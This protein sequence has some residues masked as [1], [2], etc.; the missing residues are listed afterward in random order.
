MVWLRDTFLFS[1]LFTFYYLIS[2]WSNGPFPTDVAT[3]SSLI[4]AATYVFAG[5]AC[6]G[7]ANRYFICSIGVISILVHAST[8]LLDMI[9]PES[10]SVTM[11]TATE[12][13]EDCN[14]NENCD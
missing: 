9:L 2:L 10:V 14:D 5:V 8:S 4:N 11:E 1:F 7:K 13:R 12:I 3:L 6:K